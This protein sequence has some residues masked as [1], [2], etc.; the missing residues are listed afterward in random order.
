MIAVVDNL[1]ELGH[2]SIVG[3][4]CGHLRLEGFN[5]GSRIDSHSPQALGAVLLFQGHHLKVFVRLPWGWDDF[6]PPLMPELNAFT[7]SDPVG[8]EPLAYSDQISGGLLG[9][10]LGGKCIRLIGAWGEHDPQLRSWGGKSSA[11]AGDH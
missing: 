11:Q 7:A 4:S 8:L 10:L 6:G 3:D 5:L 9:I 1:N 2:V